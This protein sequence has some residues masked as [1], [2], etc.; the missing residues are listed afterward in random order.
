MFRK[1]IFKEFLFL[2]VL[3]GFLNYLANKF[4]WYWSIRPFDS[5]MHFLGGALVVSFFVWFY[6]YS[7]IFQPE[8]RR[9][10]D[11]LLVSFGGLVFVA[12]SWE[13][14]ELLLG[15]AKIQGVNYGFDTT[16]DFIMDF[17]G[18]MTFC[19]YAY[20]LEINE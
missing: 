6:F 12:V 18:G 4:D 20:F 19:L 15:E 5:L 11:F 8:K 17:L 10:R 1:P 2:I 13:V 9:L 7:N 16:L 14:Y 3:V